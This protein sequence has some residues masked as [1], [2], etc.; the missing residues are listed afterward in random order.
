[1][2]TH[3]IDGF[4]TWRHAAWMSRPRIEFLTYDPEDFDPDSVVVRAHSIEVEVPDDF[5]PRSAQVAALLKKREKAT[6]TFSA[7]VAEIDA[8]I[9]KLLAIE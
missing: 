4:I 3:T 7:Y 5:D 1:M 6:A 2:S 9:S 8:S